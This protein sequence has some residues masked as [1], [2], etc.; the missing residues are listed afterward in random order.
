DSA[1]EYLAII[2]AANDT[3]Q[4]EYAPTFPAQSTDVSYGLTDSN[5]A[6][7]ARIYFSVPTPGA[8]NAPSVATPVFTVA[9]KT[10]QTSMQFGL[11]DSTAGAEI[12][13]TTDRTVPTA[14]SALYTAPV[15]LTT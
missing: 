15:T 2:R 1:G 5:D 10:F 6:G 8:A 4:F 11:T 9:G 3:P 14:T 7:S 12:R 13:Y